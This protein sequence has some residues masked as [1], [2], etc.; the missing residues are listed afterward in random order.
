MFDTITH[1]DAVAYWHDLET[2]FFMCF[3]TGLCLITAKELRWRWWGMLLAF[4]TW[5]IWVVA[6]DVAEGFRNVNQ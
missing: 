2:V 6:Y 1:A 3:C 4:S 5:A